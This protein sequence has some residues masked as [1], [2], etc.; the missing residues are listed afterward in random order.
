MASTT[1]AD[2]GPSDRRSSS[3]PGGDYRRGDEAGQ[4]PAETPDWDLDTDDVRSISS[5]ELYE[6][7]PNRWRGPRSTWRQLTEANRLDHDALVSLRN[8]D[9]AVH[10][11]SAFVLKRRRR[12]AKAQDAAADDDDDEESEEDLGVDAVTGERVRA[13]A[14][15]PPKSWTAWPMRAH[16]VPHE[17]LTLGP[18]APVSDAL[19]AYTVRP[20]GGD[21][22]GSPQDILEELLC[23]TMLRLAK[24]RFRRRQE[25]G[26]HIVLD[27][28]D[29]QQQQA[30]DGSGSSSGENEWP[31]GHEPPS[32]QLPSSPPPQP[33]DPDRAPASPRPTSRERAEARLTYTPAIS[34]DD[35]AS[36]ALLRPAARRLVDMLNS[37][38]LRLHD[39][40]LRM[41][42]GI[43]SDEHSSASSG[44]ESGDGG[45]SGDNGSLSSGDG[46]ASSQ[47]EGGK[48][49]KKRRRHSGRPRSGIPVL[50]VEAKPEFGPGGKRR[51]GRPRKA[52]AVPLPGES[53]REMKIR[54]AR[55]RHQRIPVPSSDEEGEG[56]DDGDDEDGDDDNEAKLKEEEERRSARR[57]KKPIIR[58]AGETDQEYLIRVARER[59]LKLPRP[60]SSKK[61][62][63]LPHDAMDVDEAPGGTG[64]IAERQDV[65]ETGEPEKPEESAEEAAQRKM[66]A[67][68]NSMARWPLRN[69]GDV[70]GAAALAGFP[71]SAVGRATQRCANLFGQSMEMHTIVEVPTATAAG[72]GKRR[73]GLRQGTGGGDGGVRTVTYR[74]GI[75]LSDTS[76]SSD[77]SADAAGGE[78]GR[79]RASS[80]VRMK[81][82]HNLTRALS[83]APSP[84]RSSDGD[85]DAGG[86]RSATPTATATAL[87]AAAAN[88]CPHPTCP[89]SVKGFSRPAHLARHLSLVHG[90]VAQQQRTRRGRSRSASRGRGRTRERRDGGG[91][92]GASEVTDGDD[93]DEND[94]GEGDSY[95][96][97]ADEMDG[98]VHVDGFL[99]PIKIR[100][101]WRSQDTQQRAVRRAK[102]VSR[103]PARE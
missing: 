63:L 45:D 39:T 49:K 32:A 37:A 41:T 69:W 24:D 27:S 62:K 70:V 73:R 23:A 48:R 7:R 22:S 68:Q 87:R 5:S 33:S 84:D 55:E 18:Q 82:L 99:Q 101:G 98:A 35:E 11:Y 4:A 42:H 12:L 14:W 67:K 93:D 80:S 15:A 78:R 13:T 21:P 100:P 30:P 60:I 89:R 46:G 102:S 53:E 58:R 97:S 40:R 19:E 16:L 1:M 36:Y 77:S 8:Q 9:L 34:A 95:D 85:N 71:P 43:S 25:R 74:P 6:A 17:G 91:G 3:P 61:E 72:G 26:R 103:S 28:H 59:H 83:A 90:E 92:G 10:L 20:A 57:Q 75:A 66:R 56:D 81:R 52:P 96:D 88:A 31:P 44:E 47:G 51:A 64:D 50:P 76:L 38:L 65:K 79:C 54:I 2:A 29:Q 94:K 86:S